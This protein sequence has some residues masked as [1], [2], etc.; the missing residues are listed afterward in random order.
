[1]KNQKGFTLIELMVVVAIIGIL[2]AIAIPQYTRYQAKAKVTA[3]V[4]ETSGLKAGFDDAINSGTVIAAPGTI[5]GVTPTTNCAPLT[6]V[7]GNQ[8]AG[9]IT[10]TLT[11]APAAVNGGVIT[12]TRTALTGAWAC[13]TAGIADLTLVPRSCA[14]QG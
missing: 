10:C 7:S 9:T 12:W 13:T 11:N 4:A 2:A 5:G 3:G 8:G 1:M 14:G 6:A